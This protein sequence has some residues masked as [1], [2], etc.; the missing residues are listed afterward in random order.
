M[1]ADELRDK[2]ADSF[3]RTWLAADDCDNWDLADA[4]I[5]V[6]REALADEIAECAH[7]LSVTHPIRAYADGVYRAELLVRGYVKEQS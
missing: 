7:A 5:K 2:V 6:C 1:D 4:A 3:S